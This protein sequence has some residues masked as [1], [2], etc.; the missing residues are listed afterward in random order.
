MK[1]KMYSCAH[2]SAQRALAPL[3][4]YCAAL[5]GHLC[6]ER[7][8]GGLVGLGQRT[9]CYVACRGLTVAH[10]KQVAALWVER[11]AEHKFA[12]VALAD[13]IVHSCWQGRKDTQ[14]MEQCR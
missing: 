6:D 12:E 9:G 14:T 2:T 8:T 5:R 4:A 13:C 3:C 10:L 11:D 7:A 1:L